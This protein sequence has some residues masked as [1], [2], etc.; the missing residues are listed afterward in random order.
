MNRERE[1]QSRSRSRSHNQQHHWHQRRPHPK[2]FPRIVAGDRD[3]DEGEPRAQG[4]SA[5]L[6]LFWLPQNAGI[7]DNTCLSGGHCECRQ[8]QRQRK[9]GS[10]GCTGLMSKESS[11]NGWELE[12]RRES[13][14]KSRSLWVR[15]AAASSECV[16]VCGLCRRKF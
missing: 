8:R 7:T 2:A 4:T 6:G 16:C 10:S 12:R 3:G 5:W 14:A 13:R 9:C 11:A 1:R 15:G